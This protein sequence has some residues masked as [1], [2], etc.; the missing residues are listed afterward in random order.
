MRA[1][2][3]AKTGG[4]RRRPGG[5]ST[6]VVT[7]VRQALF[8]LL[9]ERGLNGVE[10]PEIALRAGVNRTTIYRRWPT[11]AALLLALMLEEMRVRVPTP[12]TGCFQTDLEQMLKGIASILAD[13]AIR[14]IFF[15]LSS[16]VDPEAARVK[17]AF[18]EQRFADSGE[19]VTRAVMRGELPKDV[20]PRVILELAAAP[21]L[22]R[23]L[24][25]GTSV[26]DRTIRQ[27]AAWV[28]R[29]DVKGFP[30]LQAADLRG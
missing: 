30:P 8:D 10:I 7:A 24:I 26:D 20:S 17:S 4:P 12:N 19:I 25:L 15:F 28:A 14:S 16:R 9:A 29:Q 21:L 2:S 13:P 11:K 6:K 5:R 3:E 27:M 23:I 18:W 1:S 22:Y